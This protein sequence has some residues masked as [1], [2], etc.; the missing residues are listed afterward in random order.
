M[1]VCVCV[2]ERERERERETFMKQCV[3]HLMQ[4]FLGGA[5]ASA[6]GHETQV[7][8]LGQEDPWRSTRSWSHK[9]MDM[10]E[11]SHTKAC[12]AE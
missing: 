10:N 3:K 8:F 4:G 2:C 6:G 1:C 11:H 5:S 12:L 7:G 9:E